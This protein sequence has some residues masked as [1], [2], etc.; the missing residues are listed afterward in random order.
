LSQGSS[1]LLRVLLI[2]VL[3]VEPLVELLSRLADLL[4]DLNVH[5]FLGRL[6]A[7][8]LEDLLAD[9]V[10]IVD[11][12]ADGGDLGDELRLIVANEAL[13]TAEE[14]LLVLLRGDE[15]LEHRGTSLDL[16]DN[17]LG[18][19][20]LGNDSQGT[21]L[22]LDAELLGLQVDLN[23]VKLVDAS[24]LLGG[25]ND[26][27]AENIVLGSLG[28]LVALDD[29]S[30]LEILGKILSTSLDG[31]LR[32]VDVPLNFLSLL[33]LLSALLDLLGELVIATSVHLQLAIV[34]IFGT[35]SRTAAVLRNLLAPG[36]GL[37]ASATLSLL[38]RL[39]LLALLGLV[40]HDEGRELEARIDL[41]DFTASLAVE[42]D[43][44]I[45]D[46]DLSLGVFALLAENKLGDEAIKVI[47]KLGSVVST[48]DDPAVVV[49]ARVGL[50][51][52]LEA[53][54]LDDVSRRTSQR[55][56]NA[57]QVDDDGLDAVTLALDLGLE[58]LHLV[59]VEGVGNIA[60]N[61]NGSH[62]CGGEVGWI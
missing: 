14:S 43:I 49:G 11:L 47:L 21:V 33:D 7:P 30:A 28:V 1:I 25:V 59:A 51:T 54:V 35:I 53:E 58:T 45:L 5:V 46:V 13:D 50:S 19:E 8:R 12:D 27:F 52:K 61:V 2:A 4:A 39:V 44:A 34:V 15:L 42:R 62:G 40:L 60:A 29:K 24:L 23:A 48:V 3:L 9:K 6:L 31:R 55:V 36:F 37:L 20:S 16:L 38:G 22:G 18:E 26:P 17:L 57:G 10:V 56:G 32:G 41:G